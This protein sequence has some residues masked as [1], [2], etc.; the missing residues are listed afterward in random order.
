MYKLRRASPQR[1][2]PSS[3]RR[4]RADRTFEIYKNKTVVVSQR[5]VRPSDF[6]STAARFT[7]YVFVVN[8]MTDTLRLFQS[9]IRKNKK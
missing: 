8:R 6:R 2:D 5:Y 9:D 7:L 4:L 1:S 3:V